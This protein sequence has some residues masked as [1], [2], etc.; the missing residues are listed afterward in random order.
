MCDVM[1]NVQ[2]LQAG[3]SSLP[4]G[5]GKRQKPP[6]LWLLKV[7]ADIPTHHGNMIYSCI[8]IYTPIW[9]QMPE[10]IYMKRAKANLQRANSDYQ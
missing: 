4:G 10:H 8:W 5:I 2:I 9:T 7:K 3:L 1:Q 6:S